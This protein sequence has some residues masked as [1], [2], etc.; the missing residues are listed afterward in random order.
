MASLARSFWV[1]EMY[2]GILST[3]KAILAVALIGG[4]ATAVVAP[5]LDLAAGRA[6]SGAL[7]QQTPSP[8]PD[9]TGAPE[10]D[11][12]TLLLACLDSMDPESRACAYA[13]EKSGLDPYAFHAKVVA[14]MF[15]TA[16]PAPA[17]EPTHAATPE[18]TKAPVAVAAKPKPASSF[19]MLLKACLETRDA[20]SDACVRAGTASGLSPADWDAKLRSKLAAAQQADF[21][22]MFEKCLTTRDLNSD[23]C[24]RA[25]ELSGMSPADFEAKFHAKLA[26]KDGTD[27]WTVFNKC[28]DTRDVTTA[29]CRQAQAL[30]G[31]NDADFKA[32]FER[33][34]AERDAQSAKPAAT[35]TPKPVGTATP[36]PSATSA[37]FTAQFDACGATRD[38]N[39]DACLKALVMSGLQPDEFWKKVQLTFGF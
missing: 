5:A 27:F 6:A 8:A 36:K 28:L 39:S 19:D 35:A 33:Y 7:T 15:P 11:F 17:P 32:K 1:T 23:A 12:E 26:A 37:Q 20:H 18:P 9:R 14:K 24:V 29:V 13:Q 22:T 3:L 30:I 10:L 31:Y 2:A 34:L 25:E 21:W 16:T 4:A 38:R